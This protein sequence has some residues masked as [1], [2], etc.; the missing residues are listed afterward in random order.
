MILLTTSY[1]DGSHSEWY[2]TATI[3]VRVHHTKNVLKFLW[4]DQ[5]LQ[6]IEKKLLTI[7]YNI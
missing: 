3:D 1:L 5:A 6:M 2:L 7:F 4:D